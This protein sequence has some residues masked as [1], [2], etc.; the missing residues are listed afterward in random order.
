ME[1]PEINQVIARLQLELLGQNPDES[2]YLRFF[3]PSSDPRKDSDKGRKSDSIQWAQIEKYQREGRGVYFVANGGG[4]KND[5]VEFGC[6]FFIE[7]DDLPKEEQIQLWQKLGLPKPTLQIDTGGKSIHTYWALQKPIPISLW[8][9]LQ[10][11]LLE[12]TKADRSIKNPAR[13]MRLGG[14]WH[15]SVNEK[16]ETIHNQSTIISASGNKY[17]YEELRA[18]VPETPEKVL[19]TPKNQQQSTNKPNNVMN[20]PQKIKNPQEICLPVP[21]AVPLECCLAKENRQ[22]L[23]G[24]SEGER[25]S[26]GA[27]LALDLAGTYNYLN[28]IGQRI[29]GN[30]QDLLADYGSRC[31]P[32]LPHLEIESILQSVEK[33]NP[34]PSCGAEGVENCVKGWYWREYLKDKQSYSYSQPNSSSNGKSPQQNNSQPQR[35]SEINVRQKLIEILSHDYSPPKLTEAFNQ[36]SLQT[37]WS[38]REI[39]QLASEIDDNFEQEESR[40]ERKLELE[41]LI[42]YKRQTLDLNMLLPPNYAKPM[43]TMA[44]WME[45]P[46]A[47]MLTGF[48]PIFAGN[49]HPETRMIVKECLGFI[50]PA[51]I[52]SGIVT[53]SGQRKSPLINALADP[54]KQLQVEENQ[55][56]QAEK[57][58]YEREYEI[59][60][61]QKEEM[62]KEEWKDIEPTPPTKP[63]ELFIDKATMEAIDK[64]KSE[65]PDSGFL[66][67]KDELS[68]LFN[69]Y[70]AYK[71][72]KG[73]D[74][75]SVLSGW[76]GRGVKKNLKGE[77]TVFAQYDSMSIFGAIQD[78]TLQKKMGNFDDEQGEWARFL[79]CLIPL[80]PLRLPSQ[81]CK[82]YLDF[83]KSLYEKARNLVPQQYRFTSEAQQLYDD[84]YWDLEVRRTSHPQRGMR[85]AISKMAGYTARFAMILYLIW[86]LEAG[87]T[88]PDIHIPK[89]YVER[90]IIISE[91]FL[92]QV[93]LIHAEGAASLGEGGL[94][95]RLKVILDKL[96]QFGELSARKVQSSVNFL[97]KVKANTIRQ[98]FLELAKLGYAEIIGKGSKLKIV[99]TTGAMMAGMATTS[100]EPVMANN[101]ELSR[102]NSIPQSTHQGDFS[103]SKM[104][105]IDNGYPQPEF[106]S[107]ITEVNQV[108]GDSPINVDNNSENAESSPINVDNIGQDS[109][110]SQAGVENSD[111][112]DNQTDDYQAS[113]E[114]HD[115]T[116]NQAND[117]HP[118]VENSDLTNNQANNYQA[119]GENHDLTE[120]QANNYHPSVENSDLTNN[121]ANGDQVSGENHDLVDNQTNGYYS[122]VGNNDGIVDNELE[123]NPDND[124][125]IGENLVNQE[126]IE[127]DLWLETRVSEND[128]ISSNLSELAS[129]EVN[130]VEITNSSEEMGVNT[131]SNSDDS[132][133]NTTNNINETDSHSSN[134]SNSSLPSNLD[135]TKDLSADDDLSTA[136]AVSANSDSIM[137]EDEVESIKSSRLSI[138]Q[139]KALLLGCQT[140]AELE[141]LKKRFP[142]TNQAY[143]ELTF[144][145]QLQVDLLV[146]TAIPCDIYKYIG[147]TKEENGQ[148]LKQGQLVYI[149]DNQFSRDSLFLPIFPFRKEEFGWKHSIF[150]STNDLLLLIS[151]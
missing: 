55:R 96:E 151:D 143:H 137:V 92:S 42:G 67:L 31:H 113:L 91:F 81:D 77:E 73:D 141:I 97:R 41:E 11:D 51:I 136:P 104:E 62:S 25:N 56:Y 114:N 18:I 46:T 82:F 76:N 6:V 30:P 95:P 90:A 60:Q 10:R 7:H 126:D 109:G 65:Q 102:F 61:S 24:V 47:A 38:V 57:K 144:E 119:S 134:S 124:D 79:W 34:T 117:Y 128:L 39:R 50:E 93:N 44:N 98:D 20:S 112:I 147:E 16:G 133:L 3:Y 74:K 17:I 86:Q 78:V 100:V 12:Y 72:G 84:Y 110:N 94:T 8:K 111:L 48:F 118:S 142:A 87:I 131:P 107:S 105:N 26:K 123:T 63:R 146:V 80:M 33:T 66:W 150:V 37:A 49:L 115:L 129:N 89:E 1:F 122:Q 15:I 101:G 103:E 35:E 85:A 130:D 13:L 36:L 52:Y 68:G 21:E 88:K 132:Q 149:D 5:D 121:Q 28:S 99:L 58:E 19:K 4:H 32:P 75:E 71:K 27:Q 69:S 22:L 145:Q 140:L 148:I 64:I 23:S 43:T 70:N 135:E 138:K 14:G 59:W 54:L 116:E 53:E 9:K 40:R 2:I 120:N 45:T 83:L 29:D 127:S 139:L 106:N 108:E 125:L